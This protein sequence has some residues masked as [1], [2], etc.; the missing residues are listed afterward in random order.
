MD[1]EEQAVVL[2]MENG[3]SDFA[4]N[5]V[6]PCDMCGAEIMW[7]PHNPKPAL[8]LCLKCGFESIE[9]EAARG[10]KIEMVITEE[11]TGEVIEAMKKR[12]T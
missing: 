8:H 10:E 11:T 2:C 6:G 9:E 12:A 4:D 1:N 5:E 7:R 3:P